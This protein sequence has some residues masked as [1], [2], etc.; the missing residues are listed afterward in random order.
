MVSVF[1][2]VFFGI[3]LG[4]TLLIF[5]GIYNSLQGLKKQVERNW[6]TLEHF[7][8]NRDFE[9]PRLLNLII[10]EAPQERALV[11][12]VTQLKEKASKV[13][14]LSQKIKYANEM[15]NLLSSLMLVGDAYPEL[16]ANIEFKKIKGVLLEI[17]KQLANRQEHFNATIRVFNH[18]CEQFPDVVF[19][20]TLGFGS[21]N[22]FIVF[23]EK[24]AVS[25]D[26]LKAAA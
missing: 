26:W 8:K 13:S 7:L 21:L 9:I 6:Q 25:Q 22:S 1:A 17:D 2:T 24:E 14:S 20:Q 18:Q 12:K 10:H 23:E 3:I 16:R 4:V 15:T 19:A 5:T 11:E